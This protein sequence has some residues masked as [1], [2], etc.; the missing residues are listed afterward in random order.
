MWS[1]PDLNATVLQVIYG[2]L[3]D[4]V[5]F[6]IS[7]EYFTKLKFYQFGYANL[8]LPTRVALLELLGRDRDNARVRGE[9]FGNLG[10]QS[11]QPG[12]RPLFEAFDQRI[13]MG[14]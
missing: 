8:G 6:S 12:A 3:H 11:G 9:V 13:G 7:Q 1:N 5:T 10:S 14:E 4:Q 2:I